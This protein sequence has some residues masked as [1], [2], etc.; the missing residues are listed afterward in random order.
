MGLVHVRVRVGTEMPDQAR[1][2]LPRA[3]RFRSSEGW[4][5]KSPRRGE[6]EDIIGE[7]KRRTKTTT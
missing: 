2:T 5:G 3:H 1:E 7:R 4:E 6:H